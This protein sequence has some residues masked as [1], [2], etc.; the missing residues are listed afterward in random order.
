MYLKFGFV[1][2]R[3]VSD[4]GTHISP[5]ERVLEL[6]LIPI[7]DISTLH[8]LLPCVILCC[9]HLNISLCMCVCTRTIMKVWSTQITMKDTKVLTNPTAIQICTCN[10]VVGVAIAATAVS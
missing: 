4:T 5:S 2:D 8:S 6:D 10:H 7:L 1:G 3:G 9:F